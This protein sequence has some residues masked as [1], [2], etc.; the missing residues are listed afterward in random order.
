[1]FFKMI[2]DTKLAQN[3]FLIG[4]QRTGEALI[5]D[6]ERDVDTYHKAA[7]AEGLKLV[8]AAETHIHA[9]FASGMRELASQGIK[10]YVSDEGDTNWK[11]EWAKDNHYDA[12]FVKDGDV[13]RVGNIEIK[14][15]KTPG[16]TPEHVCFLVTDIGGGAT[17]PMGMATGDYIFVGDVG[18]PDLLESAAGVVGAMDSSA[19]VLY[20][21]LQGFFDMPDYIKLWPGHGAGSACGKALG[22]IPDTTV[23]YEK[24]F[25]ASVSFAAKSEQEFV[26]F[27]LDGQPEPPLYFARM[28]KMNKEGWDIL[29]QM[30][31]PK[32]FSV[33]DL[34]AF[35]GDK[36]NVLVDTR[37][38]RDAFAASHAAGA[39]Y[40][41]FNKTFNTVA[42]SLIEVGQKMALLIAENHVDEAVRDLVRVGL[43]EIVGYVT[44]E[45]WGQYVDELQPTEQITRIKFD[46]L[47]EV[48]DQTKTFILDVRNA[49]E[50]EEG[51]LPE[52]H[53]LAY[54]RLIPRLAEVPKDRT[55]AV[56]CKSGARAASAVSYLKRRGFD[57]VYIDD[58]VENGL[59]L[60][61]DAVAV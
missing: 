59:R 51:H 9:D 5:I 14:V 28:K 27:I 46:K 41:P 60:A 57:V 24:R 4:C 23:G 43:D 13:F 6:P 40:A 30:P 26:D 20:N 7:A 11:Y 31:A 61:E 52:A 29:G 34:K 37:F 47:P 36:A 44:P 25:N 48:L 45:V 54:T 56:H 2:T 49:T 12:V 1:M 38:D 10:V 15:V 55:I 22:A 35:L 16:H 18:R 53:N 21:T 39:I 17:E 33:A 8:A 58:A 3:A 42:G 32:A 50:F 19:R